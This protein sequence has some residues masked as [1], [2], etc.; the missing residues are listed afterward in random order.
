[1]PS[2]YKV[3]KIKEENVQIARFVYTIST[4]KQILHSRHT[5]DKLVVFTKRL[6]PY[7]IYYQ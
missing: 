4:G 2:Y 7:N 3:Y 6:V 5:G 1:M